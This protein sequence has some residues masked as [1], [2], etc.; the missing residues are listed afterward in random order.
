MQVKPVIAQADDVVEDGAMVTVGVDLAGRTGTTGVCRVTWGR[1]PTAELL[2]AKHDDDL[3]A[4]MRSADMT[5]LDSPLGWPV[6]FTAL[7]T[8]HRTGVE[9]PALANHAACADGR[10]GLGNTFT[11]R[12]TDDV[13]WKR[14]GAGKQRPLSVSADKLGIVAIRA[15]G[16]LARLAEGGPAI[17]RD[18][19]GPVV[20][21]YPA[22]ALIQW[23]L[24]PEG[25]YKG[26]DATA[27][28]SRIL[29]G[30][31]AGLDLDL[32][33]RVRVRCV[34]SDHDLDALISAVV[35]RAAA[36]GMTHSPTTEEEHAMAAV[37]G[38]MHL[39]RR[40]LPLTAVRDGVAL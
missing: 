12:L 20:E 11:H 7:L 19:S 27:A 17:P 23:G 3:L 38:W 18:G 21:V 4:A 29:A 5:G 13:A 40:D 36:C 6:A 8:A 30:L 1:R 24:A 37:E 33:D 15:V 26:K 28:R 14:T 2:P 31:E 39:P 34:A 10:P 32:S 16:L 25:T 35:A 22:F 9:L